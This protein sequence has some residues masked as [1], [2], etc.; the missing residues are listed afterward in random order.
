MS[1]R[2]IAL[3]AIV[4]ASLLW[5]S[6]G[7]VTKLLLV[8]F[9]PFP[10]AFLRFVFASIFILPFFLMQRRPPFLTL[11]KHILPIA[12][13]SSA[14]IVLFY[15]GLTFTTNNAS[16]VIYAS[17]PLITAIAAY[18]TIAEPLTMRK[19]IGIIL[20]FV[21]V[22]TILLLPLVEK[23][24]ML[25]GNITGNILIV[26]ASFIWAAYTI[27]SRRLMQ[28]YKYSPLVLT[29]ISL[30]TSTVVFGL[31]AHLVFPMD[32]LAPLLLK[33]NF[34]LVLHL[35]LLVTVATYLL[36]QWAIKHSSATTA[37]LNNYLQPVFSVTLGVIIL[38]EPLTT[39]FLI[40]SALVIAGVFITSGAQLIAELKP[41]IS[42]L[43]TGQK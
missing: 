2:L 21:G 25:S 22:T 8:Y 7:V 5:A 43:V 41:I 6:A 28:K 18:Y 4:A 14:N 38:G 9:T 33:N 29:S 19:I 42:R 26:I 12:L 37:S 35:A 3:V 23:G 16:S 10:L 40:G 13:L 15:F 31:F 11:V 24:Q 34:L 30:F 20:G 39:G 36:F 27:G 32:Y 1:S 17:V